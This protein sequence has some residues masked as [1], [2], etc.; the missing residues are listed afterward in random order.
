[1]DCNLNRVKFC[2]PWSFGWSSPKCANIPHRNRQFGH[3]NID[4]STNS[5]IDA[6]SCM[7][8]PTWSDHFADSSTQNPQ[9]IHPCVWNATIGDELCPFQIAFPMYE[10]FGEE[11]THRPYL[12][13]EPTHLK[14][15]RKSNW[16]PFPQGFGVKIKN[17]WVATTCKN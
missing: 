11:R 17:I 2:G 13:V 3:L 9:V 12:V 4:H 5:R 7:F 8:G 16:I 14:N 10:E 15:I 6:F 1:M